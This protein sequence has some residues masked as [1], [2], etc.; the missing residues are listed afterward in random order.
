MIKGNFVEP[1]LKDMDDYDKPL[2]LKKALTIAAFFL[3][4]TSIY[5]G[6]K[7]FF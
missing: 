2:S 1:K 6:V 5:I 3:I 7:L 4:L